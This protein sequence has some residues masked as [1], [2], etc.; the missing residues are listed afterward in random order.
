MQLPQRST[1]GAKR[2]GAVFAG[3]EATALRQPRWLPLQNMS[4][5]TNQLVLR[6]RCGRGTARAPEAA[7]IAL[8]ACDGMVGSELEPRHNPVGVAVSLVLFSQGS[9]CLATLGCMT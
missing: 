2:E 8:V 1:K 3:M 5:D 7:R 4:I 9:S 6:G